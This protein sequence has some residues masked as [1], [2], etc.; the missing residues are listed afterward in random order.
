MVVDAM[1]LVPLTT[2]NSV[3]SVFGSGL[4]KWGEAYVVCCSPRLNK[5]E[6]RAGKKLIVGLALRGRNGM[7]RKRSH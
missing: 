1:T 4:A 5:T 7:N 3:V 2:Q 6:M